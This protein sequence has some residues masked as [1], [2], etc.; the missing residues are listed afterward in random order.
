MK[1]VLARSLDPGR[2][3]ELAHDL[4]A[5]NVWEAAFVVSAM[6]I[7]F[8]PGTVHVVVVDPGVGG[9]RAPIAIACRESS[10]V[11]GPDN[12]VL[13]PLA[14]A[15]GIGTAYRIQPDRLRPN[16]PRVGTTFDGRDIFAPAA[17]ALAT[18]QR[19]SSLGPRV[20]PCRLEIPEAQRT[21]GGSSG[22][23]VHIDHF[24]NLISNIPAN[25]VPRR[26]RVLDVRVGSARAR[27]LPWA[28]SY[29]AFGL[30]MPGVL[31]SSFGTIEVA[32]AQGRAADRFHARVGS[33]VRVRWGLG[34]RPG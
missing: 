32:V 28:T 7:G 27:R 9:R 21:P 34:P 18:G 29:E 23:I 17:A 31:G 33:S 19:P 26:S 15:L 1:A 3:V 30:G 12:G 4:P 25:W 14:Q 13:Y 24:G 5:H 6:G 8:P 22:E 11:V 10:R 16:R 20:T 2:I